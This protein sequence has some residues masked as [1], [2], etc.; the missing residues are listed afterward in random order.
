MLVAVGGPT[1][2]VAVVVGPV[3]VV[4]QKATCRFCCQSEPASVLVSFKLK[5]QETHESG[6]IYDYSLFR[7]SI[8][9]ADEIFVVGYRSLFSWTHRGQDTSTFRRIVHSDFS[10]FPSSRR[11]RR[12]LK[13]STCAQSSI[14]SVSDKRDQRG[15]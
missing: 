12:T 3:V 1:V 6:R 2:P 14:V 7:E 4:E 10:S 11:L 9:V 5:D 15:I 8:K 13:I